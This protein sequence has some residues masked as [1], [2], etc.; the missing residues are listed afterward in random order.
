MGA[1]RTTAAAAVGEAAALARSAWRRLAPIQLLMAVGIALGFAGSGAPPASSH[2]L[3]AAG[4]TLVGIAWAPLWA[5]LFELALHGPGARGI[6]PGGFRF[7]RA[8]LKLWGLAGGALVGLIG[9]G[10]ALVAVSAAA[11][12]VLHGAGRLDLGPLGPALVGMV[13][14]AAVWIGGLVAAVYAGARL[15]FLPAGLLSEASLSLEDAWRRT[16]GRAGGILAVLILTQGPVL[17]ALS[18]VA[19]LDPLARAQPPALAF[20]AGALLGAAVA[21]VQAPLTAGALVALARPPVSRREAVE[22][23]RDSGATLQPA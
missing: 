14:A 21:F 6:G 23:R 17:L 1:D 3:A 2:G 11:L 22:R 4:L 15:A 19:L 9:W 5:S 20:A 10:L 12:V 13:A 16:R 8:E 7:G 18:L